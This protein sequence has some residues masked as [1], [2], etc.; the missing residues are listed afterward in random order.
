MFID[1]YEC[2]C[3]WSGDE[4]ELDMKDDGQADSL[5][6]VCPKCGSEE[7]KPATLGDM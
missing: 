1:H 3:G 2:R 6:C 5:L 4:M 7:L